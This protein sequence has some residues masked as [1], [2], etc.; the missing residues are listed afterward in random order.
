[1]RSISVL[2]KNLAKPQ[3]SFDKKAVSYYITKSK[4][5]TDIESD[6]EHESGAEHNHKHGEMHKKAQKDK[7]H[8]KENHKA[9]E[10]ERHSE[11]KAEYHFVCRRPEKLSHIDVMLLRIFPGI[12][13]IEVQLLTGTKQ[14]AVELTANK[15]KI[16]F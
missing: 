14:T 15:Y 12:E 6:S 3:H 5:D 10:H 4:V 16:V 7:N 9:D 2:E 8:G 1:M 13:H 11:F